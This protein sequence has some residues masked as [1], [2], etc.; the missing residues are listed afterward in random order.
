MDNGLCAGRINADFS[1][2]TKT[3]LRIRNI[4]LNGSYTSETVIRQALAEVISSGQELGAQTFSWRYPEPEGADYTDEANDPYC[5]LMRSVTVFYPEYDV[6]RTV[7][8][9]DYEIDLKILPARMRHDSH[10]SREWAS[11]SGIT[12]IPLEEMGPFVREIAAMMAEDTDAKLLT[13]LGVRDYDPD[14]SFIALCKGEVMG[15]VVCV[16]VDAQTVN[17]MSF[18]TAKKFRT[19]RG[20]GGVIIAKA[21][22]RIQEKYSVVELFLDDKTRSLKRFYAHYFGKAFS[23]RTRWFYLDLVPKCQAAAL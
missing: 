21:I 11:E 20:G 8:G 2:F 18:Y 17:F 16:K 23:E 1:P 13:P 12:F 19:Y 22:R 14:T 4:H 9:R 15:W 6:V 7:H 5:A 10:F 3:R